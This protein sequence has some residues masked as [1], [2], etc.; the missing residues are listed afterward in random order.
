MNLEG[1]TADTIKNRFYSPYVVVLVTMVIFLVFAFAWDSPGQ[2]ARGL[3]KITTSRA[4][5]ISDYIA[6]G[7]MG[8]TL[9]NA[10]LVGVF[11]VLFVAA[12]GV[13][14]NGAIIMAIWMTIGFAFFG[15]NIYNI[16]PVIFGVWLYARFQRDPF[17]NYSLTALLGSTLAPIVSELSFMGIHSPAID[18]FLGILAGIAAG[19][20]LP[21][22]ATFVVRAH[23]GYLLY[24]VGFT[25]GIIA[26][27][28]S[29][30]LRSVGLEFEEL[31]YWSTGYNL[32]LGIFLYSISAALIVTGLFLHGYKAFGGLRMIMTRPG[33]LVTDFYILYGDAIYMNMGI[34]CALGT[35]LVLILGGDLNGPT[36]GGVITIA[37]FGAFGKHPLNITPV[38]LGAVLST[39][40]NVWDATA[41]VNMLAI[42]FST[43]LA[44]IAG[45]YGWV[46]GI[47]AGLLHV[48]VANYIGSVN[49]GLNLYNN[50]FAGGLV[51]LFL[52]PL[53]DG[54]RRSDKEDEV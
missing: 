49:S 48:N 39:Y 53:I 38:V 25:G 22:I 11:C 41:P 32:V 27:V 34:L 21:V 52:V 18:I 4:I 10:A 36:M 30:A 40:I 44:P 33:R 42:L 5:L 35:T 54:L 8:A 17:T 23:S 37:A 51:A 7:G 29:S 1:K 47:V 19:F 14:P 43:G 20:V 13:R 45:H 15:K 31:M 24:N 12:V 3:W 46:C 2:I 28:F 16:I 26:T 9:V 6:L 50:G